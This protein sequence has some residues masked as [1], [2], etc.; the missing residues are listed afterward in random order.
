M[1][2]TPLKHLKGRGGTLLCQDWSFNNGGLQHL[3]VSLYFLRQVWPYFPVPL[4]ILLEAWVS[5]WGI[6]L[7]DQDQRLRKQLKELHL[8]K[9][10]ENPKTLLI[11]QLGLASA[12]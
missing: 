3:Q 9:Q 11:P 7:Y 10:P 5:G 12:D 1:V 8:V 6:G 2:R 4:L